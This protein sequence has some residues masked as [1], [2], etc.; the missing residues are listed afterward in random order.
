MLS[1]VQHQNGGSDW[2]PVDGPV[3]CENKHLDTLA[4]LAAGTCQR[5]LGLSEWVA[6]LI[7]IMNGQNQL[8]SP[9]VPIN[10]N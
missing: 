6:I 9:D 4:R 7:L 1:L 10:T 3:C 8:L 2:V 5:R